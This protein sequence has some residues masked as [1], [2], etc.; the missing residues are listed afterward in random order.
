MTAKALKFVL[1]DNPYK[2]T[3]SFEEPKIEKDKWGPGE[4]SIW[5]GIEEDIETGVNGFNASN[6]LH[7]MIQLLGFNKGSSFVIKKLKG[8]RYTYFTIN[9]YKLNDIHP[10]QNTSSPVDMKL[11]DIGPELSNDHKIRIIWEWGLD[12]GLW[13]DTGKS[14]EKKPLKKKEFDDKDLPF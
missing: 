9:D 10:A 12:Q 5:Y 3:L 14:S 6:D 2:V 1:I 4:D 13:S 11:K 7:K 8:D